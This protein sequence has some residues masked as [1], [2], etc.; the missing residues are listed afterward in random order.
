MVSSNTWTTSVALCEFHGAPFKCHL[1]LCLAL[2]EVPTSALL[3]VGMGEE[4]CPSSLV[5]HSHITA[6]SA[7]L[8]SFSLFPEE[9]LGF[10]APSG[11][12][13]A[14]RQIWVRLHPVAKELQTHQLP[15][16]NQKLCQHSTGPEAL[17]LL[18]LRSN[19]WSCD[20]VLTAIGFPGPSQNSSVRQSSSFGSLTDVHTFMIPNG[21][22]KFRLFFPVWPWAI[23]SPWS[24]EGGRAEGRQTW[25]IRHSVNTKQL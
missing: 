8:T 7:P 21:N 12:C 20:M 18:R 9:I 2:K 11:C 1:S 14:W 3:Q 19:Y 10:S 15:N 13:R 24:C 17:G 23:W 5:S 4:G 25:A 6:H 22:R 16:Q